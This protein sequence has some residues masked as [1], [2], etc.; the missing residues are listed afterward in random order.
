MRKTFLIATIAM[1]VLCICKPASA[2]LSVAYYDS[3]MPKI[4]FAYKLEN[5][6]W[7]EL[8]VY[9]NRF[10]DDFSPEWVACYDI[11]QKDRHSIYAGVGVVINVFEGM[12]VPVGLQM[13]P[14]DKLKD[15]SFHIELMPMLTFSEDILLQASW[16]IRYDLKVD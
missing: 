2:Q 10:I 15:L 8:R 4:G 9:T 6:L 7:T 1:F 5:K 12:V 13:R 14:F 11:S 16:G 3:S